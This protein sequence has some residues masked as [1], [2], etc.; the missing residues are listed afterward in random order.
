[1]LEHRAEPKRLIATRLPFKSSGFLIL[2]L[3]ISTLSARSMPPA[4]RASS[5]PFTHAATAEGGARLATP[6][7]PESKVWTIK[8]PPGM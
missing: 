3:T 5:A 6:T 7:S 8:E 2:G 1:M 4:T